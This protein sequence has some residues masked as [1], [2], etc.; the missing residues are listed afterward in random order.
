MGTKVQK[1]ISAIL[2]EYTSFLYWTILVGRSDQS[3][4]KD[5]NL[6]NFKVKHI[7]ETIFV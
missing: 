1:K 4:I 2:M 5:Q 6:P 3:Y 7:I